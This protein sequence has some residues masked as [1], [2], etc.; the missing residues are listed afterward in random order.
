MPGLGIFMT[1]VLTLLAT[2]E[3]G[4]LARH[5]R[6]TGMR[7]CV[8]VCCNFVWLHS[9]VRHRLVYAKGYGKD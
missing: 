5:A 9:F 4:A 2:A 3:H 7:W 8:L 1:F 6:A